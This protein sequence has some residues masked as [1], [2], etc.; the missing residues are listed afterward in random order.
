[1]EVC[2]WIYSDDDY[3]YNTGCKEYWTD[4]YDFIYCPYCGKRIKHKLQED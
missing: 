2:E 3:R 1:M 4:V